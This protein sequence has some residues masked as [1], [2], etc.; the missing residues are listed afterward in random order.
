MSKT[1]WLSAGLGSPGETEP[2]YDASAGT[3]GIADEGNLY[4]CIV[5][6]DPGRLRRR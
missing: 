4:S 6:L 2:L 1:S 3:V 5:C